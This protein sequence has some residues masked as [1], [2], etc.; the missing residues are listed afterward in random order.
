MIL[1]AEVCFLAAQIELQGLSL[2]LITAYFV[3]ASFPV[4]VA[5]SE[6]AAVEQP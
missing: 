3:L 6:R 4:A 2:S 1:A 5:D